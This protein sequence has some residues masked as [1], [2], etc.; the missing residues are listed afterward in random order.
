MEP[1]KLVT[2]EECWHPEAVD[3]TALD[4]LRRLFDSPL[5]GAFYL[6]GRTGLALSLGHRRSVDL[7]LFSRST[8][9]VNELVGMVREAFDSATVQNQRHDTLHVRANGTQISFLEYRYPLL[10][11]LKTFGNVRIADPIDIACMKLSA[12]ASRGTRRDF[13]DL[14]A[15][16]RDHGLPHLLALIDEK[17][18]GVRYSRLHLLK[19]LVYFEDAE[20]DPEP[21]MRTDLEW[22]RVKQ[23][24]VDRVPPCLQST[25]S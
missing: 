17:F 23:F 3:A 13:V 8:F 1:A 5:L 2:R 6:A 15:V 4:A 18:S 9:H 16:A 12:I 10:R 19:S 14:H 22:E 25:G 21:N 20:K 24:F 11:P 7:D